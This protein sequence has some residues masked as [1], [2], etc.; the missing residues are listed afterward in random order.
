MESMAAVVQES[1]RPTQDACY[2]VHSVRGSSRAPCV[3]Q[4]SRW[5]GDLVVLPMVEAYTR[6]MLKLLH[7]QRWLVDH[8]PKADYYIKSDDDLTLTQRH[9]A[10]PT[11]CT[12]S[13]C[14]ADSV[15]RVWH[16]TQVG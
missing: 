12:F 3:A 15:H 10:L 7:M 4:E 6:I 13:R 14:T 9:S 16:T 11:A 2:S 5:H 8:V 1:R